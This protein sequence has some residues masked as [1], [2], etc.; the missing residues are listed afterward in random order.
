MANI[1]KSF[2]FRNGVQ[3]DNDNFVVNANG[4]V[5]I[6]TSIPTES[7]DLIGNAKITGLTTTDSLS[8]GQTA[9][10]Y[11]DLKVGSNVTIDPTTGDVT[12]LKFY[13]DGSTLS[14]VLAIAVAGF[15]I[16]DVGLHTLSSVGLGTTNQA[17]LLQIGEDPSVGTGVGITDGN[18]LVSGIVTANTFKGALT[19][20]VT[21]TATTAT[22]LADGANI[23]TG[24]IDNDRLPENINVTGI[25]TATSFSGDVTGD[26][27]GTATTANNLADGANIT[28]GTIDNDRL[29]ENINVT[30]IITATSFDASGGTLTADVTGTAT[31]A[32]NLADGAN[33]TTGTIDDDR[34]PDL[35]TSNINSSSGVSTFATLRFNDNDKIKFGTSDDLEVYYD[36]SDSYIDSV[37]GSIN[38]RVNSSDSAIVCNKEDSVDLYFNGT[39][40]FETTADGVSIGGTVHA[41][42]LNIDSSSIQM[43]AGIITAASFSG[44]LTGTATTLSDAANIN[45]GTIDNDRLPENINVTGIITATS[46]SGDVTGDV[47]GTATNLA[48]GANITTGTIDNDRLPE[49]INVTGIITATSFDGDITGNITGDISGNAGTATSLSSARNF[50]ITG[51]LEAAA[52]SFDGTTGCAMTSVLSSTFSANTTGIITSNTFSGII[53][54][55]SGY[56]NDLAIDKSDDTSASLVITSTTNS[57][58]SIG[59][60]VG[61]GNS[62]AQLIYYPGAGRL[63]IN[64]YDVGGVNIN[65]HEGAGIGTTESFS[66]NYD[67]TAQFEVT[68]DGRAAVNRSGSVLE[69]NFE[70]GGDMFVSTDVTVAGIMTVGQGEFKVTLG[71]GSALPIPTDQNFN[72]TTGISTFKEFLITNNLNIGAGVTAQLDGFF[73][74]SVGI[75]S[76][77]SVGFLTGPNS[78]KAYVEGSVWA[79]TGFYTAGKVIITDKADGGEYTD[80]DRI[81]PSSPIDYGAVVPYV[82]YGDF[83]AECGGASFIAN[84][85]MLVPSVGVATVGF[86]TTNGGI[87]PSSFLP[88]NN[89]YLSKVGINTYYSR[90][91][92]DIGVGSTTMNS[93]VILPS[94]SQTDVT[95]V[96]NLWDTPTGTGY[97]AARKV[98][99]SGVPGGAL[100]YNTTNERIEIGTG[101]SEFSGIPILEKYYDGSTPHEFLVHPPYAGADP[102]SSTGVPDGATYYNTTSNKLRLKANGSW[103][104]LN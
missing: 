13:G 90:G 64:N 73:G 75:G 17:Y 12:A 21:G 86:G 82:N 14:N 16:N 95:I 80:D 76:T 37:N 15:T 102:E 92:V 83:Q 7:L 49:N 85:L 61:A 11:D 6:G 91:L 51:D 32:N 101:S 9:N 68:Y 96:A 1:R 26:V 22:N 28:T 20:D 70:V 23:T 100:L 104:D 103:V 89:R 43:S 2:N 33:I 45:T 97:T 18:I 59:E 31:T 88:G 81:I 65:L 66:V 72:V 8:V 30:G 98:T 60:S 39:K 36:S 56:F 67:N 19:G 24:T 79:K 55:T 71:D 57:S 42:Q 48:D 62:S 38:L 4:L 40:K 34:L 44:N 77:N 87:I 41:T 94:L 27:T 69:H 52:V 54:S 93:Y 78:L 10:F 63:D 84:N 74:G 25:I 46:F 50:S 53:T 3:V 35:I 99:P 5:G 29:P 58:V 47:T